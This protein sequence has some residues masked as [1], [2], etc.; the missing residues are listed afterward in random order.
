MERCTVLGLEI[1]DYSVRSTSSKR[2]L[3]RSRPV[4]AE[5]LPNDNCKTDPDLAAIVAAA[6]ELPAAIRAGIVAMV[7]SA[8]KVGLS[9]HGKP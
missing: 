7:K 5:P 1:R 8:S 6:P 4:L 3:R 9:D 2:N